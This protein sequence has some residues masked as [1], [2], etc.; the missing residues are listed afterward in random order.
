VVA[1]KAEAA[2][3]YGSRDLRIEDL[4]VPDPGSCEVLVKVKACG[5]CG[6]D[7]QRILNEKL[8]IGKP[9]GGHEVV[10]EVFRVG[11]GV[12]DI[13]EGDRVAV[14]HRVPCFKCHYCSRGD[15][16]QCE[17]YRRVGVYPGGFSEYMWVSSHNVV[18][19]I[20]KIPSGVSFEAASFTEPVADCLKAL[21]RAKLRW[22]DSVLIIGGGALGLLHL[23]IAR[24]LGADKVM[25]SDHHENRIKLAY[26][27]G[28]D[29]AFDSR[30]QDTRRTVLPETANKG[31]DVAVIAAP[32]REAFT[33]ALGSVRRGGRILLFAGFQHSTIR[34]LNFDPSIFSR[35]EIWF[36][37]SYC[38]SPADFG[39][40]LNLISKGKVKVEELITHK[41]PLRE[42]SKAVE[43]SRN[44][45]EY[46]KSVIIP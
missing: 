41:F 26:K 2:I 7:I 38:Y 15:E 28:A 22:G 12:E 11:G 1:L 40:A 8:E 45:D 33:Q 21:R 9:V 4:E 14:A 46:L 44:K 5:L 34:E 42:M 29:I 18:K 6:S 27:L 17:L 23:Q 3:F 19:G 24:V 10:G 35:D 16:G 31:V 43:E 25:L 30:L 39:E 36:I 32:S 13:S 37:G 20:F